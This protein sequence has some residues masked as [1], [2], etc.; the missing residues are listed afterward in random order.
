MSTVKAAIKVKPFEDTKTEVFTNLAT[1]QSNIVLV[2]IDD[3]IKNIKAINKTKFIAIVF[4]HNGVLRSGLLQTDT[5][6]SN[7]IKVT[8]PMT[9]AEEVKFFDEKLVKIEQGKRKEEIRRIRKGKHWN[10]TTLNLSEEDKKDVY[11]P[12]A[13]YSSYNL[14]TTEITYM[15]YS[16]KQELKAEEFFD[17]KSFITKRCTL[18]I[19]DDV[20]VIAPDFKKDFGVGDLVILKDDKSDFVGMFKRQFT[21]GGGIVVGYEMDYKGKFVETLME[22]ETE[23]DTAVF[24]VSDKLRADFAFALS[25]SVKFK[26]VQRTD[27]RLNERR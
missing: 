23:A 26:E 7:I 4:M 16:I 3:F 10:R 1:F 20:A 8:Y 22:V 25:G 19:E 27:K 9:Q 12:T 24:A 21:D 18:Y 14:V 17:G 5:I 15:S 2:Q 6:H 13:S 11:V